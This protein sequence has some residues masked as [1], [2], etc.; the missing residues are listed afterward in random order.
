[1]PID[2]IK[3]LRTQVAELDEQLAELERL[4]QSEKD[5]TRAAE[6]KAER[7]G[8]LRQKFDAMVEIF[9]RESAGHRR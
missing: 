9:E 7:Y 1:M 8:K 3:S 6:L 2:N 5:E 4:L